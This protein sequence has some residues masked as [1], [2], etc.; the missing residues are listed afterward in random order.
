[1]K[2]AW[3]SLSI[4]TKLTLLLFIGAV[5][6]VCVGLLIVAARDARALEHETVARHKIVAA[7]VADHAAASVAFQDPEEARRVL[8]RLARLEDV[9]YVNLYD[10]SG[11]LFATYRPAG[12]ENDPAAEPLQIAAPSSSVRMGD[13]HFD[14]FH[15]VIH[16]EERYGTVQ[17]GISLAALRAR[18]RAHFWTLGGAAAIVAG[19]ALAF[20]VVLQRRIARRVIHLTQLTRK[21]THG[22][23]FTVRAPEMG[24]DEIGMLAGSF[25]RMLDEIARRQAEIRRG[26]ECSDFLSRA[27]ALLVESLDVEATLQRLARMAVPFLGD[28]C[29]ID[30]VGEDGVFRRV[31]GA[32]ADA[33]QQPVL[34]E[35]MKGAPP[36]KDSVEPV[37]LVVESGEPLLFAEVTAERLDRIARNEREKTLLR[38]LGTRS[39]LVLPLRVRDRVLGAV[40]LASRGDERPYDM[41]DL[42]LARELANRVALAVENARLFHE[43]ED[44]LH[45]RETFVSIA[46][47]ELR[48]PL[49][50]LKLRLQGATRASINANVSSQWLDGA[51]RQVD[52]LA[53][54]V[55]Q[56]LELSRLEK[57]KFALQHERIDLRDVVDEVA[58][59][60]S[61][62]FV[63]SGSKLDA[64]EVQHVEGSWD[65]LRLEQVVTNL[66]TNALKFG[67][68]RP[69]HVSLTA[70]AG[71]ARLVVRD[72]G[73]GIAEEAQGRIFGAF[74]RAVSERHYGGLGLGL[75][76]TKLIVEAHGGTIRL[77]SEPGKGATFVVELPRAQTEVERASAADQPSHASLA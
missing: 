20:A 7:L 60:L 70:D 26:K 66:L 77:A 22:D 68:G 31:A 36:N 16:G 5:L 19:L 27:T 1:M 50:A 62:E 18:D 56:L 11:R 45:M 76:I 72:E 75:Y 44:A 32:H 37:A 4:R 42:L 15:P 49:T 24:A 74:E 14:V 73:L 30:I 39:M 71:R 3:Q 12:H 64:S 10:D 28:W 48:T 47:H 21:I 2:R 40:T 46:A 51:Q 35:L 52:R 57:G 69:I 17:I 23:S 33:S 59:Q 65:R 43:I 63:N 61:A 58:E 13:A 54:L 41:N 29:V 34:D 6:P 9:A 67:Q 8:A 38:E 55:N 25:N 53:R